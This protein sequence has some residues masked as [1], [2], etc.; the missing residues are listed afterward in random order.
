M[1]FFSF[2]L[3]S[4]LACTALAGPVALQEDSLDIRTSSTDFGHLNDR[5][6]ANV[7]TWDEAKKLITDISGFSAYTKKGKPAADTSVFFTCLNSAECKRL[8][9]WVTAQKLTVVGQIWKNGN[10]QSLGQYKVKGSDGKLQKVLPVEFYKFQEAFSEYYATASSGKAYLV[11]PHSDTPASGRKLFYSPPSLSLFYSRCV[12]ARTD[13][14]GFLLLSFQRT[15]A[16]AHC[17][18][19]KFLNIYRYLL[20][21]GNARHYQEWQGDRDD[22][23]RRDQDFGG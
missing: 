16:K 8:T 9:E 4:S 2:A 23:A 3:L 13:R 7:P 14:V 5:A 15:R 1:K 18:A 12:T 20:R 17:S 6:E 22:V 11:F 10:L 19:A 21:C